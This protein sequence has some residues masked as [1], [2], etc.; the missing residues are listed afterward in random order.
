MGSLWYLRTIIIMSFI[1]ISVML[2]GWK[3]HIDSKDEEGLL[4]IIYDLK[5]NTSVNDTNYTMFIPIPLHKDYTHSELNNSPIKLMYELNPYSMNGTTE[6]VQIN[7]TYFLKIQSY[8][9]FSIHIIKEIN[10]KQND[11]LNYWFSDMSSNNMCLMCQNNLTLKINYFIKIIDLNRCDHEF[12]LKTVV[13]H[14]GCQKITFE[15]H[16]M[17]YD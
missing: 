2:Y 16:Q 1:L 12:S 15:E 9:E 14:E 6:I 4:I 8:K 17:I 3:I 7:S 11:S 10:K 13:I 5:I